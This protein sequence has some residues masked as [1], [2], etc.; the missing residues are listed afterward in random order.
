MILECMERRIAPRVGGGGSLALV[1]AGQI[2]AQSLA[3][4][5]ASI[6]GTSSG[7]RHQD[8]EATQNES[9]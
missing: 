7:K 2:T 6:K 1:C 4:T 5:Q 9:L 3:L 8:A